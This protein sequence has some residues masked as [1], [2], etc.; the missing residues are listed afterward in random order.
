MTAEPANTC[1]NCLVDLNGG[2]IWQTFMDQYQD[3]AKADETAEMYGATRTK[4]HWKRQI[5]IYSQERDRTVAWV[6]PDCKH[7]WERK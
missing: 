6:C 4:G 3:E 1:P 7:E 2:L 5:G